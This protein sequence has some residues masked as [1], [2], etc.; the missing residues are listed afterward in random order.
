[1]PAFANTDQL[2]S[3]LEE[4]GVVVNAKAPDSGPSLLVSILL[5]FGPVLLIILLFVMLSRRMSAPA[6]G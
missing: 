5:G 1:M 2:S 4:N 6:A 3:L